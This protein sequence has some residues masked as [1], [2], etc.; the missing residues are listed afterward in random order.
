MTTFT[1]ETIEAQPAA[2]V[3]AEVPM[4]QLREVFDR[5]FPEVMRAAQAQGVPIAGPPFG[6]YP[7]MPAETVAVLVGFPVG[8][9]VRADGDVE[10]FE[11]P[12][13]RVVTGTHIGPYDAL[14]RTYDE[15]MAWA[16]AQGLTLAE[17]M[18]ESYLS[19][20]GAEPDPS[21]WRTL[22]VWPLA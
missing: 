6:F 13:G 17:G 11:M 18:W 1:V 14:A 5:G 9:A 2:V 7:R 21:T 22:I 3:R 20:P 8:G 15:L 12:G 16:Q 4:A 10:P 19:D